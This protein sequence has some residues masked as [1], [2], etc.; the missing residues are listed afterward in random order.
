M[1]SERKNLTCPF[2]GREFSARI[3]T[4]VDLSRPEDRQ[5]DLTDGSL[6]TFRCPHCEKDVYF[7]HYLLWVD[8]RH[9]VAVCN[10]TCEEEKAAMDEALSA[11]SAFGKETGIRRRY[12]SSPARLCEKTAIFSLGLDDRS[13]EIVKLYFAEQVRKTYPKKI[14]TDILFF[15]DGNEYGFLFQCPDGDLSVNLSEEA[16]AQA[17]GKFRFA[18]PSPE[19][20]DAQWAISYLTGGKKQC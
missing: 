10:L 16:F 18:E 12:V 13:V 17:A 4:Q 19:I 7:N 1:R 15:A 20:V 5:A 6:F 8:D 2:C 11:L 9:T 14:L 3:Y